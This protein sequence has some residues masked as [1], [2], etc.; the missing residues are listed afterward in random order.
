MQNLEAKNV[1]IWSDRWRLGALSTTE[2]IHIALISSIVGFLFLMFHLLGN[3][4][5]NVNTR[6]AFVWMVARWGD[7]VSFGGADYSHGYL[8][9]FVS[10]GVIWYKR[11]DFFKATK[12]VC[13]WGLWVIVAAL[14]M[15]WVGAKMQQTRIS[16]I[17]LILLL[18]GVPFYFYGWEVAK[19]LI[20]PCAYLMFCVP[21]NFLDAL[22]F[23]LQRLA[24]SISHGML[25]GIGIE[26]EKVGT[27]LIGVNFQLNVEAPCSGLR[28]LLAMTALTAVY[29][30]FTQD[31]LIKKWALFVLSIPLAV[32]G[33]IGRIISIALVSIV[34]GQR[35][36][37]G[38]YHDWSGYVLF[39]VAISLMVFVGKLLNINYRE[40]FSTW[41]K[42]Y[43]NHT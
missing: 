35:L 8:I 26:C 28:S 2:L 30:Y 6:S 18:W 11:G 1:G 37:T 27:K 39:T 21:L 19:L 29:A 38:L 23:P 24:T 31:T 7:R 41:R 40:L 25:T 3:T 20:F 42:I 33:N 9:P 10:L 36:G 12:K 43:L 32:A 13:V 14:L 5:E 4:V 15:H 34:T 22:S 17:S 16:L